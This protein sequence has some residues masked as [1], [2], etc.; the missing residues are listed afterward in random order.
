MAVMLGS[1]DLRL[2]AAVAESRLTK[3]REHNGKEDLQHRCGQGLAQVLRAIEDLSIS[4]VGHLENVA[5]R[6]LVPANKVSAIIE[7]ECIHLWPGYNDL[8]FRRCVGS[9]TSE[10]Y[11]SYEAPM[12]HAFDNSKVADELK[13]PGAGRTAKHS[14]LSAHQGVQQL[15][16]PLRARYK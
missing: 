12:R 16:R 14:M 13:L 10:W 5:E 7:R 8:K 9:T 3:G 15:S 2:L 1:G 6:S 4:S 11:Q